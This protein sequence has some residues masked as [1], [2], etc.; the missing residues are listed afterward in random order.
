M[1]TTQREWVVGFCRIVLI[2]HR[3]SVS[4]FI[5]LV[6]AFKDRVDQTLKLFG[7]K[8]KVSIRVIKILNDLPN[9]S[10]KLR[11]C[12]L[13]INNVILDKR[14]DLLVLI[15]PIV[16]TGFSIFDVFVGVDPTE[17]RIIIEE[18]LIRIFT[19]LSIVLVFINY[20]PDLRSYFTQK[21]HL[22]TIT[23]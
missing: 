5:H 4:Y 12:S 17:K 9:S 16:D 8:V 2:L 3:F 1:K 19:Q 14:I 20:C 18:M 6:L 7:S 11:R 15:K 10:F 23:G 22:S 13:Q 21:A